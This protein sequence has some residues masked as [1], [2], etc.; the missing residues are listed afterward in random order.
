MGNLRWCCESAENRGGGVGRNKSND[1][2][3]NLLLT[4]VIHLSS[5][6]RTSDDIKLLS[7][8]LLS[9]TCI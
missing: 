9:L 8:G 1:T 7:K 6:K 2:G 4:K 3:I 5:R